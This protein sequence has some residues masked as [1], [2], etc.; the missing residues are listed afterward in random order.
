MRQV[1]DLISPD[2]ALPLVREWAAAAP[3]P[4]ELLACSPDDGR[5]TLEALQVTT[6]SPL[7][8]VAYHTGGVLVDRGWLRI[9]GAAC[10]RLPRALDRWNGAGTGTRRFERGLLV[11][12]DVLGGFF[13]WFDQ[14]RSIHYF[15]SDTLRWEDLE[16]GYT[17]WLASM[18]SD[19]L[20]PF[21][22]ALRW[23]GWEL[24]VA[25]L[26]PDQALHVYPPLVTKADGPRS[27]RAVPVDELWHLQTELGR[28]LSG[29]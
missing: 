9:L 25:K 6:R 18:L 3:H 10:E 1:E 14:P 19:R 23:E 21:Y 11:G 27:R 2:D 7:G 17:D 12:D 28:Q 16:L 22:A 24:E 20:A 26:R 4:V 5:R 13:A 15:A 29:A 8:A